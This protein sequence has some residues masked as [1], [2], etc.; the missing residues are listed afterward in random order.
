MKDKLIEF[1]L[2]LIIPLLFLFGF[3][4]D[5]KPDCS[6]VTKGLSKPN[7]ECPAKVILK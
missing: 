3:L 1:I 4:H 2:L 6:N 5:V 7:C